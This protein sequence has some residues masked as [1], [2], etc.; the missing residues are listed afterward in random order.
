MPE[1]KLTQ[2]ISKH[3]T[4]IAEI[5]ESTSDVVNKIKVDNRA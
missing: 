3:K 5:L 4:E 1:V 2:G